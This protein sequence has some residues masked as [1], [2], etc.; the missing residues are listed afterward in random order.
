M[1]VYYTEGPIFSFPSN[2]MFREIK[3]NGGKEWT[4]KEEIEKYI[5]ENPNI[6]QVIGYIFK[7]NVYTQ[8]KMYIVVYQ[9]EYYLTSEMGIIYKEEN[10]R[11]P[12]D[13]HILAHWLRPIPLVLKPEDNTKDLDYLT[14]PST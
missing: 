13:N 10:K 3:E 14:I 12:P 11:L 9:N 7:K 2:W 8:T 1:E 4:S 6:F 5:S